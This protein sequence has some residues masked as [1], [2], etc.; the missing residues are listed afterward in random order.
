MVAAISIGILALALATLWFA[1]EAGQAKAD[2]AGL[3]A[4]LAQAK[5]TRDALSSADRDELT[6]LRAE[7][8]MY[9]K[10]LHELEDAIALSP[11]PVVR[12]GHLRELSKT[13]AELGKPK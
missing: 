10:R 4:D 9:L 2:N 7:R 1:G 12:R 6:R 3:K 13:F 5:A 8:D 11:D